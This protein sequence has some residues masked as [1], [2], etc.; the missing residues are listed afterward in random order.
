MTLKILFYYFRLG[1]IAFLYFGVT[2][3]VQAQQATVVQPFADSTFIAQYSLEFDEFTVFEG[4]STS[5]TERTLEGQR[6]G[7]VLIKPKGKGNF[8]VLRSFENALKGAGFTILFS[9]K[10]DKGATKSAITKLQDINGATNKPYKGIGGKQ[11][12]SSMID[13]LRLFPEYYLSATITKEGQETM[14]VLN[15]SR[16][17]DLYMMEELTTAAME[18]NTVTINEEL[19]TQQIEEAG[20]AILYGIEFDT[21]SAV[22]RP[23]SAAALQIV[24]NVLKAQSGGFY[25][26]GHT[27]DTGVFDNN[28]NLSSKR[29][30]SVIAA[31]KKSYGIDAVRLQAGGVGPLSP[32]ASNNNTAGK[33][34]NR[35]VEL[36]RRLGQ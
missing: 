4:S 7:T 23:S 32:V 14:F 17:R 8:E 31:L 21:G 29:A 34:L 26:V 12:S 1:L 25:I 11:L 20:S 10:V 9:D 3:S 33:Q 35:R 18:Q 24:A 2:S 5:F 30:A 16:E 27:D 22:I 19:L 6:T 28:M 15:L 13:R 36:V